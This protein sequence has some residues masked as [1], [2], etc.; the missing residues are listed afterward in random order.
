MKLPVYF[1]YQATTPTDPRV[2]EAM[3]PYFTDQF[4]NPHSTQHARG[5]AAAAA[6][7]QAR[8]QVAELIGATRPEIVFTS[9][10]TE[11]NNLALRGVLGSQASRR[12]H[13]ITCQTEH[14]S[15]LEVARQLEREGGRVTYLPVRPNGLI[16]LGELAQAIDAETVLVSIMAV[17]NEI[18]VIQPLAAIGELCRARGVLFHTDAAQAA[19]KIPLDVE[20]QHIDLMSLSAHKLYGPKGIGALYVRRGLGRLEPVLR[21]G[22]Q[23]RGLRSGTLP[24]PLCV[25]FGV[26]CAI[27]QRELSS[28][29]E[30]LTEL[31][32]ALLAGIQQRVPGVILNGD[33][34]QRSP[35]N[36]N[37]SFPYPGVDGESLLLELPELAVSTGSACASASS[38]P[39]HVLRA[40][41]R[42]DE[43]ADASLRFGL[44]RFTT[45]E[46]VAFAISLFSRLRSRGEV[47]QSRR[48][49]RSGGQGP[50]R[51]RAE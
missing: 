29:A 13:V 45:Q 25:G 9:G 15:V 24:T 48:R 37:L 30:R 4:G 47:P 8:E 17:N 20:R 50:L 26:A 33:P 1:D 16:D 46:E 6:V 41:G 42:D 18:G 22:G 49:T 36:L 38:E 34:D 10:A 43:L 14:P 7:E 11:A 40:L 44:G 35:G 27:V 23:E 32:K 51:T 2:L 12:W 31:R 21:G 19:G 28:E 3:L 5:R 39:S